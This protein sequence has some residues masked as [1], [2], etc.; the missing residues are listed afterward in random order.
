VTGGD[1]HDHARTGLSAD[2]GDV[3]DRTGDRAGARRPG[4]VGGDP[5]P[6]GHPVGPGRS[7]ACRGG[8]R[9]ETSPG[10]IPLQRRRRSHDRAARR[11][12]NRGN[13]PAI[14]QDEPV[15]VSGAKHTG[16]LG[17]RRD[18]VLNNLVG[19]NGVG[20]LVRDVHV[21]ARS[22]LP[23]AQSLPWP[24]PYGGLAVHRCRGDC[25]RPTGER[26]V[27]SRPTQRPV[28]WDVPRTQSHV[29]MAVP[30][31]Y[32]SRHD[33]KRPDAGADP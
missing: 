29:N 3:G 5:R 12:L 27:H 18:D 4:R 30:W 2:R 26:A 25:P 14:Q 24:A 23:A 9:F 28:A 19:V 31:R 15:T 10:L 17:Q 13:A 16:V 11:H 33:R 7:R 8:R 32:A 22:A 1:R 20:F 21:I 6:E